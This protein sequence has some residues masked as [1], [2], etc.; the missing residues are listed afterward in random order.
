MI[1]DVKTIANEC[2]QKLDL[3]KKRM[4]I[5]Q[6]GNNLASNKYINGKISDLEECRG[7]YT[8]FKGDNTVEF[9]HEVL[10]FLDTNKHRYDGIV[11]QS[12]AF[13][14]DKW[15]ESV[16]DKISPLQDIDGLKPDSK[17]L[18]C[19]PAAVIK[20]LHRFLENEDETFLKGKIV[21]VVGKGKMCGMP[22]V[23]LLMKAG[24]TVLSLNSST[25]DL[26]HYTR[27]ADIVV[28]AVGK[29]NLITRDMLKENTIVIDVGIAANED[30]KM[31]GDCSP[32][33]Y[34]DPTIK[35]TPVP[36][37]VGLMTRVMLLENLRDS[38]V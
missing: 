33:L 22:L 6:V 11:L 20:L 27:E 14:V 16:L 18:P 28:S 24:A 5:I 34:D 19:T 31:C 25:P 23:P 17:H 9:Y 21:A 2:K 30:G 4:L 15:D 32:E 36:G 35:V 10:D 26:S 1:L 37:G 7:K 12:P 8:L 38:R 29:A 13:S 3:K